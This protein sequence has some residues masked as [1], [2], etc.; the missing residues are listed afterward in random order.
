M[1]I[2]L[3]DAFNLSPLAAVCDAVHDDIDWN[4]SA[5]IDQLLGAENLISGFWL[6]LMHSFP[7]IKIRPYVFMG[8]KIPGPVAKDGILLSV[9][10][11]LE[12][13]KSLHM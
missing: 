10:D 4:G 7:D 12:S 3:T 6:P 9:Q 5:P 13:R 2:R 1:T 11:P 8:G